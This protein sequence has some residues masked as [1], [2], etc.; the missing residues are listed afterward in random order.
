M[1]NIL[2]GLESA[3][4]SLRTHSMAINTTAHNIANMNTEGYSRQ[5]ANVSST[6]PMSMPGTAGQI[7]TGSQMSAIE[8][9]RDL[10]LDKQIRSELTNFG[11]WDALVR[12]YENLRAVFPE[13]D[14]PGT[15]GLQQQIGKFFESWQTLADQFALPP[16][17]RYIAAPKN[18]I[19]SFAQGLTN[20]FSTRSA[21]LTNIQLDL[22][23]ELRLAMDEANNYMK[24][25]AEYNKSIVSVMGR[26]ERPNDLLDKREV[27]LK[28]LSELINFHTGQR[29]DGSVV[30]ITGGHTI[31]SGGEYFELTPTS[32]DKDSK[33]ERVGLFEYRG[34]KPSDITD[35]VTGGKIAGILKA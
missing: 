3:M 12:T 6:Q 24:E 35:D 15:A 8:R 22:N 1:L 20:M 14:S 18:D 10:Y 7:G 28:N 25:I 13:V 29:S 23:T 16:S 11:E 5:L 31:V 33:F 19:L 32:S 2:F 27:A 30:L 17:E 26:G 4:R 9:I 34:A 21:A